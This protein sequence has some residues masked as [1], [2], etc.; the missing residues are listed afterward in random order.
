MINM[1]VKVRETDNNSINIQSEYDGTL[2]E[3][4]MCVAAILVDF[5]NS[6]KKEIPEIDTEELITCIANKSIDKLCKQ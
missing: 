6:V 1:Q 4:M 3:L 2:E 5:G